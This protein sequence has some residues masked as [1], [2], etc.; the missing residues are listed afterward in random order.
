MGKIQNDSVVTAQAPVALD[1][2]AAAQKAQL[3]SLDAA[4]MAALDSLFAGQ[5]AD[6]PC[7]L[8]GPE[9]E[10]LIE[11]E[12]ELPT[13]NWREGRLGDERPINI[14]DNS[15]VLAIVSCIFIL[16]M[17][18]YK[19][20]R[21][22]FSSLGHQLWGMRRRANVFDPHTSNE[23]RYIVLMAVQWCVYTGLL[24]YSGISVASADSALGVHAL[25]LPGKAFVHTGLLIGLMAVY[26]VVQ[27]GVYQL[28]GYTFSDSAG[29]RLFVKG[30]EA[31]QLLLG[32][33]LIIPALVAIFYPDAAAVCV[34]IGISLYIVARVIFIAKGFRIFYTNFG[35]LL[36]FIL[37]LCTLEI[38]PLIL[39][40]Q[41]ALF[42]VNSL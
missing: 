35:S 39:V 20:C 21:R 38:I 11:T 2:A 25:L 31:S 4:K 7:L 3:D 33:A 14:G 15:G 41:I 26:Y 16:M 18:G 1:S 17:L 42:L 23:T 34:V 8:I 37:Y 29:R 32:F 27:Y 13:E 12:P 28:L 19:Q 22:L 24:L 6:E 30:F 9:D 36:Y 5:D 10:A 40:C